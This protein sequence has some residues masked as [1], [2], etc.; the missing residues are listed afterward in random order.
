M[1]YIINTGLNILY[2]VQSESWNTN[3]EFVVRHMISDSICSNRPWKTQLQQNKGRE[4]RVDQDNDKKRIKRRK[5]WKEE[6]EKRWRRR[7]TTK[8]HKNIKE[9]DN[10]KREEEKN[11]E[12][13]NNNKRKKNG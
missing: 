13:N 3:K 4:G 9:K 7:R 2:E 12:K 6:G 1:P 5:P 8:M 10:E 11:V